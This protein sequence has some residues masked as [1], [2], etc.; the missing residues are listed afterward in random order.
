MMVSE[1]CVYRFTDGVS[2]NVA[3]RQQ[4]LSH[5]ASAQSQHSRRQ[6]LRSYIYSCVF[7]AKITTIYSLTAVPRSTQLSTLRG[8]V[9]DYQLS[10]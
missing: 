9:N 8:T 10:G 5:R 4:D 6:L 7:I 2:N 3:S 1:R